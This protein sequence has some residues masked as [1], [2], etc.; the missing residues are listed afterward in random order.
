MY[1]FIILSGNTC[2]NTAC[3]A[4]VS[5]EILKAVF[6]RLKMSHS[7]MRYGIVRGSEQQYA[8]WYYCGVILQ[9]KGLHTK[10]LLIYYYIVREKLIV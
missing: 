8:L 5:G 1:Q 3:T 4:T 2:R 10:I 6:I 7:A 9:I